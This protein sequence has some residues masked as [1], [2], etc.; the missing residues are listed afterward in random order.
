[1]DNPST[2]SAGSIGT[3]WFVISPYGLSQTF[4]PM[5]PYC[6]DLLSSKYSGTS[7]E[8]SFLYATHSWTKAVAGGEVIAARRQSQRE[9][10]ESSGHRFNKNS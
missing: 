5:Q 4:Q 7:G 2:F 10:R 9:D 3:V 1:M 8:L 6:A